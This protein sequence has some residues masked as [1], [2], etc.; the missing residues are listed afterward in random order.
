MFDTITRQRSD[1]T[2]TTRMLTTSVSVLAHLAI[3]VAFVVIPLWY[4]TPTLPTPSEIMA[5]VAAPPAPPPPPPPPPAAARPRAPR[6]ESAKPT[7]V[8][9]QIAAPLAPP[10]RIEPERAVESHRNRECVGRGRRRRAW[11]RGRRDRRRPCV[12]GASPTPTSTACPTSIAK[13]G[14]SP[15]RRRDQGA[16][17]HRACRSGYH[18]SHRPRNS[19]ASSSS[20]R[21]WTKRDRW[22]PSRCS[23]RSGCSTEQRSTPSSSGDTHL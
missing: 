7:P 16:R 18:L 13:A 8:S 6:P 1:A 20:K 21:L 2:A 19:R 4:F 12:A 23:A 22:S 3:L 10:S 9:Q 15:C 14:P 17:S 5:F 11:R